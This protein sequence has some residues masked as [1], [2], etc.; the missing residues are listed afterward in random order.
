MGRPHR[1]AC[2][3][4]GGFPLLFGPAAV[5]SKIRLLTHPSFI[6]VT[7][8]PVQLIAVLEGRLR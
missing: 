3:A 7:A 8:A 6:A 5:V 4:L 2:G 1:L